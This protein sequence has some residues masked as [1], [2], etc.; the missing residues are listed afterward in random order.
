[1]NAPVFHIAFPVSDGPTGGG[2]Q[3]LRALKGEF[4][5]RS[6][7]SDDGGA[8]RIVLFNSYQNVP[9]AVALR[10]I[11]PDAVFVHRVDGPMR[12]YNRPD[13]PR[14]ALAMEAN[15]L[16]ADAT[17]FQTDWCRTANRELGWLVRGPEAVIGNA[18]DPAVFRP[19]SVRAPAVR[20]RIIA[21]S[22]SSNPNKGFDAYAWLD[23]NLDPTR[24]EM[25]F[26]GN[27]PATFARVRA[28]GPLGSAALAAELAAHDIFVTASRKDPCSNSL[29][30][31]LTVGLPAV[32]RAD[33][34]H[35]ELIGSGG[36]TFL[37]HEDIPALL[38]RVA[39][40]YDSFRAAIRVPTI[41]AIA[42]AYV[43]FARDL[44]ALRTAGR[45]AP[46]VPGFA[47]ATFAR[48]RFRGR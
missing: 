16:I 27:A 22:W 30:E 32:A 36:L 17:V 23:A 7:H 48:W 4:A 24:Y 37:A 10:R 42:D 18:A 6:L 43:D 5:R 19:R 26:V 39:G 11:N 47:A 12:L 45:L 20:R 40:D 46:R 13:D 28:T 21:T 34:G 14:D 2:N 3:F 9:A 15:A 44:L 38:D 41:S 29:I 31:A 35:P 25:S 1:M 8:A 33:G